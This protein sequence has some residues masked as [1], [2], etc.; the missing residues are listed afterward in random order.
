MRRE[1]LDAAFK[2]AD[3]RNLPGR[4][5]GKHVVADLMAHYFRSSGANDLCY[6]SRIGRNTYR[7]IRVTT[8]RP[9]AAESIARMPIHESDICVIGGGIT[10]AMLIERLAE[11]KPGPDASPSSKPAD[12]SSIARTAAPTIAARSSTASIRGTTTTSRISRPR[13]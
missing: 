13:A 8:V 1:L 10:A 12:R 7:A 3:V 5:D 2:A 9:A 11:L 6:N 4:P